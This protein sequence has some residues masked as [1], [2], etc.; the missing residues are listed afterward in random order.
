MG[1]CLVMEAQGR[2]QE[3]RVSL[4]GIVRDFPGDA[5]S[6]FV[7]AN[8]LLRTGRREEALEQYRAALN[9]DPADE[10]FARGLAA[11]SSH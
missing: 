11:A 7:L 6:R 9:L 3:A 2:T 10:A 1:S 5:M 4:K 8:L